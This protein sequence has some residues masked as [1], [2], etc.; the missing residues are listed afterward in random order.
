M[1]NIVIGVLATTIVSLGGRAADAQIP[2]VVTTQV[3]AFDGLT[4][5]D[6]FSLTLT[7]TGGTPP[8][9]WSIFAGALP[10]GLSVTPQGVI[11]GTPTAGG[12]ANFTVKAT[13]TH[14]GAGTKQFAVS[15]YPVPKPK[16][17][18]INYTL[19]TFYM[20]KPSWPSFTWG[21]LR[22]NNERNAVKATK[23]QRMPLLGYYQGDSPEVLDWQIKM[24]VDRGI[25]NFMFDDYWV[26]NF[27]R[28]ILETGSKA[29]L[30]SRYNNHMSFAMNYVQCWTP[31]QTADELHACFI[32]KVLPFYVSQYFNRPNYLKIGGRPV[33][34]INNVWVATGLGPLQ[35]GE[36][37]QFLTDA[38]N[39]IAAHSS[40]PSAYWIAS[41]TIGAPYDPPPTGNGTINFG[42]VAA[43][44][45]DAIAPYYVIPYVW[46]DTSWNWPIDIPP[47][48]EEDPWSCNGN[49]EWL[50]G[51]A[52]SDLVTASENRHAKAFDAAAV[53]SVKFIT[54]ITTDFDSRSW[55]W[56]TDHLYF[57]GHTDDDY[58]GLL[59]AVKLQVD[60]HLN[61]I[62]YSSNTGK[63]L[64]GLGA[65]N[66]QQESSSVEPGMSE[67]QWATGDNW[68]PYF[69]ATAAAM[70]FGGPPY[71]S[72][73]KYPPPD[74]GRGFPVNKV[75]WTFSNATGAGLDEWNTIA[76]AGLAIGA[77][78]VLQVTGAGLVVLNTPTY[79][80]TGAYKKVK[81][82]V[83]IDEGA[84]R[85]NRLVLFTRSSDY[86]DTAH[87]F[88]EPQE[89]GHFYGPFDVMV[90]SGQVLG[91]TQYTVDLTNNSKWEG[92][93]KYL[94]LYFEVNCGPLP[95]GVCGLPPLPACCGPN[96]PH[97]RYSVKKVWMEP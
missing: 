37:Q 36:I 76:T 70:V 30:A 83:R 73:E 95:G 68:D 82:L 6:P 18:N 31:M 91:F 93:V 43:A 13:D 55:F 58:W 75:D 7:A 87:F 74:L 63:P 3:S 17:I 50:E 29:F 11:S 48:P 35:L 39:Y 61:L 24:A 59:A 42:N 20:P 64:V 12:P 79:V 69:V 19:S 71:E 56:A 1:R 84:D 38:D 53:S 52:Y 34:Q 81:A 22:V 67:F 25:T 2:P 21:D 85:L 16:P 65:W 89:D 28:P 14:G 62:P 57:N 72:Y 10:A 51:R 90:P 66:E 46:P 44:G 23:G 80:D 26:D 86:S 94:E 92:I 41:E 32:D 5:A 45:F 8:Y 9:T 88:G 96:P 15:V 54:S 47:C 40:Y 77:G 27:D 60:S 78:D 33:I 97:M 4:F 49:Y